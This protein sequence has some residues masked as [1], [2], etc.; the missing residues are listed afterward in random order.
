M[1][2]QESWPPP[3]GWHE[4]VI[5]WDKM[6]EYPEYAPNEILTWIETTPGGKYH[7]HGWRSCDGFAFRF[8]RGED[9]TLFAL[10]WS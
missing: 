9:A 4:I 10:R 7:L 5:S 2:K 1:L 6:R 3:E 8:E